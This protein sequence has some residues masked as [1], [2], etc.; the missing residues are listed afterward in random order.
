MEQ[1][2]V[3]TLKELCN[4]L[5][6][7]RSMVYLKISPESKHYDKDFPKSYKMGAR[8]IGFKRSE[9]DNWLENLGKAA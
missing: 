5:S 6:I 1:K 7:S 4:S 3:I 2:A 9:V 8:R